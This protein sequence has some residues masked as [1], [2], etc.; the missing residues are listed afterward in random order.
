MSR[1]LGLGDP[2][3]TTQGEIIERNKRKREEE[4]TTV[5]AFKSIANDDDGIKFFR[6]LL[7]SDKDAKRKPA[8]NAVCAELM[9]QLLEVQKHKK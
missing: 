5:N 3:A 4:T 6:T 1:A 8:V 2:D 7:H 9:A